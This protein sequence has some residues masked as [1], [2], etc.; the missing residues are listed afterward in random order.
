[1]TARALEMSGPPQ[2]FCQTT[3]VPPLSLLDLPATPGS[4]GTLDSPR[5]RGIWA[6]D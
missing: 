5:N 2:L 4:A 6:G 3:H 1:M